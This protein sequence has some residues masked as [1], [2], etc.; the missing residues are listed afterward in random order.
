MGTSGGFGFC[1]GGQTPLEGRVARRSLAVDGPPAVSR[2]PVRAISPPM[3]LGRGG[4]EHGSTARVVDHRIPIGQN[5]NRIPNGKQK[6]RMEGKW[7]EQ[8]FYSELTRALGRSNVANQ[9]RTTQFRVRW[10]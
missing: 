2:Y 8:S 10:Y 4:F 1:L 5:S 9:C 6:S 7:D 3:P